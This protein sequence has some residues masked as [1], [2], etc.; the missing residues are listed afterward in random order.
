[1]L[2]DIFTKPLGATQ[3]SKLRERLNVVPLPLTDGSAK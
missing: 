3:F 2:A 1:M